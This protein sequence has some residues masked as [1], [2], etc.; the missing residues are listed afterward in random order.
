MEEIRYIKP[1]VTN[2]SLEMMQQIMNTPKPDFT[3][4]DE[5]VD[6]IMKRIKA[7]REDSVE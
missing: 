7:V 3:D 4:T 6:R 5:E 1:S 2:L